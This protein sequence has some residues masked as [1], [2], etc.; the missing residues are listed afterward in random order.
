MTMASITLTDLSVEFAIYSARGRSIRTSIGHRAVG[1]M[2]VTRTR[3]DVRVI[4][5]LEQ[6]NLNVNSGDR[7]GLVGGN[8]AGKTT[9][10][11]VMSG[12]YPPCHGHAKIDG[13]VA[14]LTDLTLGMDLEATG[15]ENIL[16]RGSI[17]G[18]TRKQSRSL[19]EDIAEFTEL[20]E[21][22]SFP[23]RTYSTGMLARLGVGIAT[24]IVP[25][26]LIMDEMIGVVDASFIEKSQN[27]INKVID[28]SS[29]FVVASHSEVIIRQFCNRIV[30][31]ES[32]RI[33][34]DGTPDEVLGPA[35]VSTAPPSP[36]ITSEQLK[37]L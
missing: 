2:I 22:L 9:L 5:A 10:L 21:Y 12:V 4:Q 14:A 30:R 8:G 26:I 15:Y 25:E 3:D 13:R 32:G 23:V 31:M 29:I 24:A 19:Y 35:T 37:Q 7:L 28:Q 16:L 17:L 1:S 34:S 20:G 6:I 36:Q 33:I 27:R 18:L 11:R